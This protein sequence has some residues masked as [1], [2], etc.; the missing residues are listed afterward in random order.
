M[1]AAPATSSSNLLDLDMHGRHVAVVT[2]CRPE[3]RNAINAAIAKALEAMLARLEHDPAVRAVVLTG[4]G[5][6]AFCSGA[7]LREVAA[8][9]LD[10]LFTPSAGFAGFV[11]AER[12]KPWIAAVNGFALAGGC[13]IALACDMI[14]AVDHAQFGLPEVTRGLIASA[15]GVYRLPRALPKAVALE[16]IA[17]G[18]P[19]DAARA[20]AL[21]LVNRV[22]PSEALLGEALALADT[23][24]AN[25]PL[26]VM[27][28]IALAR[29]AA[30]FDD[31]D[32]RAAGD[33]AQARLA[34]TSDFHEGALAFVEK[35]R[36]N[37]TGR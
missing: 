19:I 37:W 15:G 25:A 12:R 11:N 17:T 18:Q 5:D 31:P 27:E 35:R 36:P 4:A 10:D 9:R 1:T 6:K 8:G 16:M 14:V 30:R 21:G 23:I 20:C 29:R 33:A 24:A 22:V 7:D 13:E 28:S 32:L 34:V 3:A 2:L 26:A